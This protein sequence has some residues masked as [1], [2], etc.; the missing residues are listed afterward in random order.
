MINKD[1]IVPITRTDLLS[2]FAAIYNATTAEEPL[3][4]LQVSDGA[5]ELPDGASGAYLAAEPLKTLPEIGA[6]VFLFFAPAYDF[7]MTMTP[8]LDGADEFVA[9]PGNLYMLSRSGASTGATQLDTN[10]TYVIEAGSGSGEDD[11]GSD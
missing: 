3:S 10:A 2:F 6:G 5:V 1:R 4:I 11:T 8:V 7:E 9:N